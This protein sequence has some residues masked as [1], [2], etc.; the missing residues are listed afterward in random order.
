M[1]AA[2]ACAY[3]EAIGTALGWKVLPIQ[4]DGNSFPCL[5]Y[6]HGSEMMHC[7]TGMLLSHFVATNRDSSKTMSG[8]CSIS[9]CGEFK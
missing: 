5:L 8:R 6:F 1:S 7:K 3:A 4:G 2:A 9:Q